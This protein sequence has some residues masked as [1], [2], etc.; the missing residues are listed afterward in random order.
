MEEA[1][2]GRAGGRSGPATPQTTARPSSEA[3]AGVKQWQGNPPPGGGGAALGRPPSN[4]KIS[5]PQS[6][7]TRKSPTPESSRVRK[8]P[9]P[10]QNRTRKSP[11]PESTRT[12]KSPSP[13]PSLKGSP[14]KTNKSPSPAS[15]PQKIRSKSSPNTDKSKKMIPRQSPSVNTQADGSHFARPTVIAGED[16]AGDLGRD[17]TRSISEPH[18]GSNLTGMFF[19]K[20]IEKEDEAPVGVY[21]SNSSLTSQDSSKS[22]QSMG[23]GSPRPT[24]HLPSP[25]LGSKFGSGEGLFSINKHQ[26]VDLASFDQEQN[27][28][29]PR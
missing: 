11:T 18:G 8:S 10:D 22:G 26:K 3:V 9:L 2:S 5:P 16:E 23:S 28:S 25:N 15:S 29:T 27:T 13:A 21:K 17:F 1:D 4:R 7:R 12:R 6:N 19:Q 20:L 14:R 24:R